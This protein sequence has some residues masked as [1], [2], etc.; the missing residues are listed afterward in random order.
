MQKKMCQISWSRA[1]NDQFIPWLIVVNC[2]EAS[3]NRGNVKGKKG[4]CI[5]IVMFESV[6]FGL[7]WSFCY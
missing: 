7:E 4:E 3:E 1:T 2:N 5:E 6:G